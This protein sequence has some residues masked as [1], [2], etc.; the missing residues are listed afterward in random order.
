MAETADIEKRFRLFQQQIKRFGHSRSPLQLGLD[1]YRMVVGGSAIYRVPMQWNFREFLLSYGLGIVGRAVVDAE[2]DRQY[3]LH[4]L[5]KQLLAA[6]I[7]T[8]EDA[9][10]SKLVGMNCELAAFIHLSWDL[11]T[12]ADNAGVQTALIERLKKP[13]LY[14]G[15]RYE[16]FVTASF[17]RAGFIIEFERE[18]DPTRKHCEFT[19]TSKRTGK[20]FSVE[21]KSRHR[22]NH[23][24][25]QAGISRLL[26]KALNKPADH[27]RITFVDVNLPHD[28][29]GLFQQAWH[30]EIGSMLT[31]L[32]ARQD[33]QRPWPKSFLFFTNGTF[34]PGHIPNGRVSTMIV[35]AINHP[36]FKQTDRQLVEAAY[37]EVGN[38]CHAVEH[39]GEPPED[40]PGEGTGFKKA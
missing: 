39:L 5:A 28:T 22:A 20:S 1:D 3:P 14:Q 34:S 35:T 11:F 23:D 36:L 6:R 26:K 15:A 38:L 17:V 16:V 31:E 30:R 32:E 10:A 2:P 12:V 19:A 40:F 21:A 7:V 33:P 4:P 25:K 13:S 24:N 27:E 37:P 29:G 18:D 9:R 8:S